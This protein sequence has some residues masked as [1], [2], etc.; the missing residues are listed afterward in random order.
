VFPG[1]G[2]P[3]TGNVPAGVGSASVSSG[4]PVGVAKPAG[5]AEAQLQAVT[6]GAPNTSNRVRAVRYALYQVSPP[7]TRVVADLDQ[8]CPYVV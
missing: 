8:E 6:S 1:L 7:I 2:S 5:A 3:G 4:T